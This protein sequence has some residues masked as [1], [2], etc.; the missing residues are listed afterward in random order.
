MLQ[1]LVSARMFCGCCDD[2]CSCVSRVGTSNKYTL[3]TVGVLPFWLNMRRLGCNISWHKQQQSN[4]L[5]HAAGTCAPVSRACT[6]AVGALVGEQALQQPLQHTV[7]VFLLWPA[8]CL[9]E[10]KTTT[11]TCRLRR[12]SKRQ[13]ESPCKVMSGRVETRAA[14]LCTAAAP[15]RN[16]AAVPKD[17]C[18]RCYRTGAP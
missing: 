7:T 2:A 9:R 16:H 13:I 4:A 15:A 10:E 11:V 18:G 6:F 14:R 5:Q 12:C 3:E 1:A 17:A 8:G